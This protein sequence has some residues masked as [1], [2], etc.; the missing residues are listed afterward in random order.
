MPEPE[1]HD[2]VDVDAA[3]GDYD[4]WLTRQPLARRA[5]PRGHVP[6][7]VYVRHVRQLDRA[8][9]L[10]LRRAW[11]SRRRLGKQ[12][13]TVDVDSFIGEVHGH[14]KQGTGYGYT[15]SWA[16]TRSSRRLATTRSSRRARTKPLSTPPVALT[17]PVSAWLGMS[18]FA[19]LSW[20]RVLHLGS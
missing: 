17:L 6:A 2:E 15:A 19:A 9:A 8:L 7:L 1:G 14:A 3:V 10:S 4:G 13:L 16:T 12:L 11:A 18:H 5:R 20:G